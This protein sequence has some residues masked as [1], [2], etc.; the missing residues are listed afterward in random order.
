MCNVRVA[1]HLSHPKQ[2]TLRNFIFWAF[3]TSSGP[4]SPSFNA[5]PFSKHP[6]DLYNI[7]FG[8]AV[9][10]G[11][12]KCIGSTC[13]PIT[14]TGTTYFLGYWHLVENF[15]TS[16]IWTSNGKTKAPWWDG[17]NGS[18]DIWL[19]EVPPPNLKS[20]RALPIS[21]FKLTNI[22]AL[23]GTSF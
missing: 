5:A 6:C 3:L 9:L 7:V 18:L 10:N 16:P 15:L 8:R 2:S 4:S 12:F 13:M 17:E 22:T 14:G 21:N 19:V 1:W 20:L 11:F 23:L